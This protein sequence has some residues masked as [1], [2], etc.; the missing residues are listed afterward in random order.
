[1]FFVS[2]SNQ[3]IVNQA[4]IEVSDRQL[5]DLDHDR[6]QV[7]NGALDGRLVRSPFLRGG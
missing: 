6:A 2:S 5:F 1:M 4:V 3:D 7:Q